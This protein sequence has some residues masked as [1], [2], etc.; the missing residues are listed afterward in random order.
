MFVTIQPNKTTLVLAADKDALAHA[1]AVTAMGI[2]SERV[3]RGVD[4]YGRPF[5]RYSPSYRRAL[6]LEGMGTKVD[7]ALTGGLLQS[8]HPLRS[9]VTPNAISTTIGVDSSASRFVPLLPPWVDGRRRKK[10]RQ[11]QL[12]KPHQG[13]PHNIVGAWLHNGTARMPARPW[14]GLSPD[15]QEQLAFVLDVFLSRRQVIRVD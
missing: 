8:L 5:K 14:L 6:A 3:A 15:D 2:I 9:L 13:V 7:L 4:M 1:M 12:S 10:W 11:R